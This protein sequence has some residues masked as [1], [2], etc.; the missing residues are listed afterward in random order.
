MTETLTAL[1]DRFGVM[2]KV[3]HP[4][5]EA[6]LLD[7]LTFEPIEEEGQ[8]GNVG[9]I[10]PLHHLLAG[11]VLSRGHHDLPFLPG[12]TTARSSCTSAV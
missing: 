7:P 10:Q 1:I 5:A 2:D 11:G 12:I 3:P 6:F 9:N 4:L 8:G